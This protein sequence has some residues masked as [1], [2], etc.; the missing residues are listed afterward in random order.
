V[1][2]KSSKAGRTPAQSSNEAVD[3]DVL[4]VARRYAERE[5]RD[6]SKAAGKKSWS[7]MPLI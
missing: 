5:D 4:E 3:G 6:Q 2:D 7:L 1:S